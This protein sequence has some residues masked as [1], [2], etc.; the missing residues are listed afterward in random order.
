[1][2]IS[3]HHPI[4]DTHTLP[5]PTPATIESALYKQ[6][7]EDFVVNEILDVDFSEE[8]EHLWLYIEK[9]G[10]NTTF[11]AEALADWAGI[12]RRDVGYSGL[13]DRH[14]ITR[15][16][17]SLRIPKKQGPSTPFDITEPD[18]NQYAQ[19]LDTHWHNKKLN[20]GT[21]KYNEF[22][23]TLRQIIGNKDKI[24]NQLNDIKKHGVPNYF[25]EQR[26]GIEGRNIAQ[27]LQWFEQGTI[28]GRVSRG[29]KNRDL[30]SI[31]LS[32]ARSLIFN[33]ILAARVIDGTWQTGMNGEAFNLE[34][35]GSIFMSEHL[36]ETLTQRL[37]EG[38]IHPTAVMWGLSND[39]VQGD[40]KQ[41]EQQIVDDSE[42]LQRLAIGIEKQGVK[43]SRRALRLPIYELTWQ[44]QNGSNE[45]TILILKFRLPTGSYATSVL[46]ALMA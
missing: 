13:K 10:L 29:K 40:A 34:G 46:S 25:G 26:F 37:T 38:D 21:H 39:K 6:S 28:N 44:W 43:A 3:T 32:A 2:N 1:M 35:T 19:V 7:A 4:V 15:Q 9:R 22:I 27:A 11:V 20:R 42:L 12:A 5:Q 45:S 16:W 36:D 33:H 24:E 30:Q 41:L 31:L 23:L 14:A 17:F 8:G 18:K